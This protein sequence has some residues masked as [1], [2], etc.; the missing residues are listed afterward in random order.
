MY[1]DTP[2]LTICL[3]PSKAAG[4]VVCA[5]DCVLLAVCCVLLAVCCCLQALSCK[6]E[7]IVTL[8]DT[9]SIEVRVQ[10][11]GL[12]GRRRRCQAGTALSTA[13][14]LKRIAEALRSHD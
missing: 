6:H 8:R 10:L 12:P 7:A 4:C 13:R 11:M 3:A 14:G 1:T 5:A 9:Q 2:R